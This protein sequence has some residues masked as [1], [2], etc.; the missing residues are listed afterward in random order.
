MFRTAL[1]AMALAVPAALFL[2][3]AVAPASAVQRTVTIYQIQD[4]TSVGHV[5]EGSTDTVTTTGV[6]S[7]ADTRPTGFGFYI[8]DQAGGNF[9][10]VLVFTGGANVFADSGY[11]RGDLITVTGRIIEFNGETEVVHNSGNGFNGV[12]VTTKIGT[13]AIPAPIAIANYGLIAETAAYAFAERYE[14]VMVSIVNARTVRRA[15][16]R[17]CHRQLLHRCGCRHLATGHSGSSSANAKESGTESRSGCR[18]LRS[19]GTSPSGRG[20][21]RG[22]VHVVRR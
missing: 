19:Q 1:R 14:G 20:G 16:E 10:G 7:G 4:T 17:N 9:S 22:R 13:A 5:V 2:A 6:I 8:Q 12:P 3:F 11:A 21:R 15:R 18:K